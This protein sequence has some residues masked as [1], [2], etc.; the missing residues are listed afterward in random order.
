MHFHVHLCHLHFSLPWEL[1]SSVC[2]VLCCNTLGVQNCVSEAQDVLLLVRML[3]SD[4]WLS[5]AAGLFCVGWACELR[6]V[7]ER[8]CF[9]NCTFVFPLH[10]ACFVCFFFSFVR[11]TT[12]SFLMLL[13]IPYEFMGMLWWLPCASQ[14]CQF[15]GQ[16][17]CSFRLHH[18]HSLHMYFGEKSSL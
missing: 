11:I 6:A 1:L 16:D 8:M 10:D 3:V 2:R 7:I 15:P 13:K 5:S 4:N 9:S 18:L 14:V 17:S 12:Y